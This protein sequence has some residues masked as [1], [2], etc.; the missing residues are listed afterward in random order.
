[1]VECF[2][3]RKEVAFQRRDSYWNR[4]NKLTIIN[5]NIK[6]EQ[7]RLYMH[8]ISIALKEGNYFVVINDV[9]DAGWIWCDKTR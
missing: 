4:G 3:I 9:N 7:E 6:S 5:K 1:M 8:Q 2:L